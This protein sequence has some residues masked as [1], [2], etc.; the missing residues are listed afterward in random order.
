MKRVVDATGHPSG[1]APGHRPV[2]RSG[3]ALLHHYRRRS[4]IR[5]WLGAWR[6]AVEV[7]LTWLALVPRAFWVGVLVG[8]LAGVALLVA[9]GH[10]SLLT[11]TAGAG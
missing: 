6:L 2:A 5:R 3:I 7:P 1:A 8:L 9:T 11:N 4:R 10:G